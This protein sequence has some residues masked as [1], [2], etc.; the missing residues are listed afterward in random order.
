MTKTIL[1]PNKRLAQHEDE[2]AMEYLRRLVNNMSFESES[3]L[4]CLPNVEAVLEYFDLWKIYDTDFLEGIVTSIEDGA[5]PE[6]YNAFVQK[7]DLG[8]NIFNAGEWIA[9]TPKEAA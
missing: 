9:Y 4:D 6:P 3:E 1:T 5:N 8:W 2:T 7:W